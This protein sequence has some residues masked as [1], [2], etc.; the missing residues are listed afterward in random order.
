MFFFH[1]DRKTNPELRPVDPVAVMKK[2]S[3]FARPDTEGYLAQAG[4]SLLVQ[5]VH[6]NTARSR[7]EPAPYS[8]PSGLLHAAAWA[9]L[10]N[11]EEL[12]SALSLSRPHLASLSDTELIVLC[13][14]KWEDRCVDHLIG[15]F[16]FVIYDIENA[17]VFCG[18]DH[19]GVRPLYYTVTKDTFA[20]ATT[21][22]A[23]KGCDTVPLSVETQWIAEYLTDLSMSFDKTPYRG[24]LKLP[25]SHSLTVTPEGTKL[26]KYH[27]LSD[28]PELKLKTSDDYVE[29]YR[30]HLETALHCRLDSDY[31]LGTELSGGVDSSTITA[32]AARFMEKDL[33]R[34]H[35][36]AFA[37]AEREPEHI[38]AVSRAIHL[39]H[40]HVFTGKKPVQDVSRTLVLLGYPVEHENATFHEPFYSLAEKLGVRT[41]LSGFG[42]DEFVTTL[43]GSM[44]LLELIDKRQFRDLYRI[45]PGNGITRLLRLARLELRRIRT[46]NVSRPLYN[47]RFYTAFDQRWPRQIL[48]ETWADRFDLKQ[49]HY[50]QA[51]FDAG[52]TDLK[53]FTLEKR[54]QPFVPTRME[55]CSLMA[56]GRSIEYRWPLLDIRLVRFFLSVPSK[57]HYH[58][59]MGRYLHRRAVRGIVPDKVAWKTGKDMGSPVG[60]N[61]S[62]QK[63]TAPP[64]HVPDLHPLLADM[65]DSDKLTR[66]IEETASGTPSPVIIRFQTARNI[67]RVAAL[68]FWLKHLDADGDGTGHGPG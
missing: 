57:E 56:L 46:K 5:C 10:D 29:A 9:R 47:P 53:R 38:F 62:G 31:P 54:W 55:N 52:Y 18:R 48:R 45:L 16:A 36:F 34:L 3:P 13:Y 28:V 27:D 37:H 59:G 61:A 4:Q 23:F 12:G 8:H 22:A 40:N 58:R 25:P 39:P 1:L 35:A 32:F 7:L 33:S 51:R 20:C 50:D 2:L 14:L 19:M 60:L 21:L 11:R 15:D 17:T 30:E 24:V 44:V 26:R 67:Q 6:W 42:G 64:F 43:H 66:Q 63:T 65:V 68:D 49:R 41:L